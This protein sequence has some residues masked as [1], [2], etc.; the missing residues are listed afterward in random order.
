NETVETFESIAALHR[1]AH[2]AGVSMPIIELGYQLIR[3]DAELTK[4]KLE[5]AILRQPRS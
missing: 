5:Q 4:A 2:R 1:L 3:E